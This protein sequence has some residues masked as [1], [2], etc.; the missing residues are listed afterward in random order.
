MSAQLCF[1]SR[2]P[3]SNQFI[4]LTTTRNDDQ[5][6]LCHPTA[7]LK[8]RWIWHFQRGL[9]HYHRGIAVDLADVLLATLGNCFTPLNSSDVT[10]IFDLYKA[11]L[12]VTVTDN[13]I[14]VPMVLGSV[15]KQQ[16]PYPPLRIEADG[17][18]ATGSPVNSINL[19]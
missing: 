4:R 9:C 14:T 12:S 13:A 5:H 18:E 3:K 19:S 7:F 6:C 8:R 2:P 17:D 10:A 15:C 1:H 16:K 11:T